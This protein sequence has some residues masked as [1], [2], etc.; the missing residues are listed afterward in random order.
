MK[1]RMLYKRMGAV[2][3]AVAIMITAINAGLLTVS[4]AGYDDLSAEFDFEGSASA[5]DAFVQVGGKTGNETAEGFTDWNYNPEA[6]EITGLQKNTIAASEIVFGGEGSTVDVVTSNALVVKPYYS[7][8]GFS[9]DVTADGI[10]PQGLVSMYALASTINDGAAKDT[11]KKQEISGRF[12]FDYHEFT[13]ATGTHMSTSPILVYYYKDAKNWRGIRISVRNWNRCPILTPLSYQH[14]TCEEHDGKVYTYQT[15]ITD[16]NFAYPEAATTNYNDYTIN[17]NYDTFQKAV[18]NGQYSFAF[19]TVA[20]NTA[21]EADYQYGEWLDFNI[22]YYGKDAANKGVLITISD[23]TGFAVNMFVSGDAV[24]KLYSADA[25]ETVDSNQIDLSSGTFAL[26]VSASG[27]TNNANS[28]AQP[29]GT[30]FD[31]L[32]VQMYDSAETAVCAVTDQINGIS[33]KAEFDSALV[34]YN[35]LTTAQQSRVLNAAR[36]K[37]WEQ[38]FAIGQLSLDYNEE[39]HKEIFDLNLSTTLDA[40]NAKNIFNTV[41]KGT[42]LAIK[43]LDGNRI[44]KY[45]AGHLVTGTNR[46]TITLALP[47]ALFP[48][49]ESM[50]IKFAGGITGELRSDNASITLGNSIYKLFKNTNGSYTYRQGWG[51]GTETVIPVDL[52]QDFTM[53]AAFSG[54]KYSLSFTGKELVL[55]N[56]AYVAKE[57][58]RTVTIDNCAAS[59]ETFVLSFGGNNCVNMDDVCIDFRKDSVATT[60]AQIRTSLTAP[61]NSNDKNGKQGIRFW[62]EIV[63]ALNGETETFLTSDGTVKD[64]ACVGTIIASKTTADKQTDGMLTAELI[65]GKTIQGKDVALDQGTITASKDGKYKTHSFSAYL[66]GITEK[67]KATPIAVRAYVK[68][69]D[70]T[71]V[72]GKQKHISVEEIYNATSAA[73]AYAEDVCSWFEAE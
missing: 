21:R 34:A 67:H 33:D 30:A 28:T 60:G 11:L 15:A 71:Y 44:L 29:M 52:A 73:G 5:A 46:N 35:R 1:R 47:E 2:V 16:F 13:T 48:R 66:Y 61:M 57:S 14:I 26:G 50:S 64:V 45:N 40:N 41:G 3:L 62:T 6:A 7:A 38:Y 9:N 10:N 39:W 53:K 42:E 8:G 51:S 70:G 68:L 63:T 72:Y 54:N 49:V 24:Y 31:N 58:E 65:N 43:E 4:A 69:T 32:K 20:Y 55:E 36:L 37:I 59:A 22:R 27:G 12:S 19:P 25:A 23:Q 56:G 18:Y 17:K